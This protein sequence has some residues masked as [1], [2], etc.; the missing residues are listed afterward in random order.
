MSLWSRLFK[1]A[2]P[3]ISWE[4]P[5]NWYSGSIDSIP[6]VQ[7]CIHTIASDIARCP[8]TVTDGEGNHVE[9]ASAVD[10]LSGQAWGDVLTGTD[11]RRWMVAETLTT[12]NAFAVVV[13]DT[14]GAPIALRPIATAD[15]SMQ[16]QTD[17]TIQWNYQGNPFDYGFVL[18]FK[19]LPTPGNPYWGTS[20]LAAASTTL[21]GLASLEAVF[22]AVSATGAL[23][24]LAFSH[25][26]AL[27]PAVRDAMRTAF[28]AQHGSAS[29]V[30]TP[31]FVGEGMKVEQLA[32]TMVSDLA[33]A[34]AA[35]AKE[36]ASIFGIP[37]AMLDASDA[38]TQPEIAQM[39]CNALLGWSASWMAEIT[40]KLA[41][42]GTRVAL[43][44]SPITQG[45]FRTAGRAYAQLLQVGALAP[46]D[47]RSRLGFAPW[48]GLDEPKPV[49]SGVTD[50]NAAAD[51]AAQDQQVDPNA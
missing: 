46:N 27:Q 49:I 17:G 34:R 13:V 25:P 15:V 11:L 36:V 40:S 21:E 50:P 39:Y 43:D 24:K 22:K 30:G 41:A 32:Q 51:A 7:R 3:E 37:S 4:T 28:M 42:P 31:I 1:R 26:G 29:T 33:S 47:V 20:P 35:G 45:D 48:P 9:G 16:Q 2:S 8:V 6:A 10:L 23:G 19:A 12:G 44:F 38:R 18:H 5:V 14:A